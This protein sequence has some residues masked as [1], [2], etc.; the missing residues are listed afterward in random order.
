[1]NSKNY[2]QKKRFGQHW[3]V[4][5]QI[6]EKIKKVAEL[7]EEDFILDE[8]AIAALVEELVVDITPQKSGWAGTP[9]VSK[10]WQA[11]VDLMWKHTNLFAATLIK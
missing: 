4:N 7:E 3:L 5:K 8:E 2:H 1:M 10:A 11:V 6:L 9:G